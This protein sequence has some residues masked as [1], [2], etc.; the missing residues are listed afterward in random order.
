MVEIRNKKLKICLHSA[1]LLLFIATITILSIRYGP[2][3][4]RWFAKRDQLKAT[5]EQG[6]I[7]AIAAFIGVQILQIVVAAIPGEF[8][9][10]AAG[11]FFGTVL[12]SFYLLVG[13]IIGTLMAFFAARLLGYPLLKIIV[14]YAKRE[15][16]Q[17]IITRGESELV[18]FVLF[19][20]PGLPKDALTYVA[21]ASPI[22]PWRFLGIS[23]LG[24]LPA[25]VVSC[26][27]GAS[28][29]R[30][31]LLAVAIVSTLSVLLILLGMVYRERILAKVRA[32]R[33]NTSE[34]N[35]P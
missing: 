22:N 14:P 29:G 31:N 25:L 19:F 9:Q 2:K 16:L 23:T 12:G 4:G 3:V 33:P 34:D 21:G 26:Y 8:V 11:Y 15:R 20:L 32:I 35:Q 24:R 10:I 5:I 7:L 17:T 1:A 13:L 18:I 28:L 30:D 6:G 27:I